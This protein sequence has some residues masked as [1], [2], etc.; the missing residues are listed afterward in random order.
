MSVNAT[1]KSRENTVKTYVKNEFGKKKRI[2]IVPRNGQSKGDG[3]LSL[4]YSV[5]GTTNEFFRLIIFC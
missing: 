5:V 1:P 4:R 2:D 3:K